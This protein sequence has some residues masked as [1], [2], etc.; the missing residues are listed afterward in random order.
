MPTTHNRTCHICEANCGVVITTEGREILSIKG[1]P[2]NAL[3]RGHICPKATALEDLQND[4][5]RLRAP[6][7]RVGDQ[8]ETISWAQAFSE[9]GERTRAILAR[10]PK[11]SAIYVGNPNAHSYG[12]ALTS[13]DL[14]KALKVIGQ[15]GRPDAPSG[16]ESPAL[17]S[18]GPLGRAGYRS[19]GDDDHHGRQPDGVG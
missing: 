11:S 3:S 19:H 12:N 16:R 14:R 2:A 18:L 5:D 10:D 7:K 9:I 1:D 17:W 6:Q 13:G 8:W 15:H 4:P